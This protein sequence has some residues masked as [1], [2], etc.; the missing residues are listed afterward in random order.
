MSGPPQVSGPPTAG[1]LQC[2]FCLHHISLLGMSSAGTQLQATTASSK[3]VESP[4]HPMSPMAHHDTSI[5][6]SEDVAGAAPNS[7]NGA[8]NSRTGGVH[9]SEPPPA[10]KQR[11]K[12]VMRPMLQPTS[13]FHKQPP[14]A[15]SFHSMAKSNSNVGPRGA[16]TGVQPPSLAQASATNSSTSSFRMQPSSSSYHLRMGTR[17]VSCPPPV[18]VVKATKWT[19]K[20]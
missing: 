6:S 17:C 4:L 1:H 12:P 8:E 15:A 7:G 18:G 13:P 19:S 3:S 5:F 16:I 20:R 11:G 9:F 10:G 14:N 2:P